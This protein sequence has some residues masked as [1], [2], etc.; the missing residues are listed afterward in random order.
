M[1]IHAVIDFETTGISPEYGARPTE[2]AIV[3]IDEGEIIDRFQSLMNPEV[4]IP[5]DI[6]ALTGISNAM[7]RNAPKVETVMRKA[8]KFVGVHPFVAHNASFDSK[9]W[10]AELRRIHAR[11]KQTFAC[12]MLLAR[13]I[14]PEAPNHKLGTLVQTLGIPATGRFHRALADAEATACLLQHIKQELQHRFNL[15]AVSHELLVAIQSASRHQL[16]D[17]IRRHQ[18]I[19]T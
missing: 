10:D 12:S 7:V 6:Q 8:V 18:S 11:R 1:T 4:P 15:E 13:R 16:D 5:Y 3:L 14:F 17:C 9:F 19:S 2:V